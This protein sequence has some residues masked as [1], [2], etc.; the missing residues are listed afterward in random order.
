M[1]HIPPKTGPTPDEKMNPKEK[2][3]L[4]D[5]IEGFEGP[6]RRE[7]RGTEVPGN[8]DSGVARS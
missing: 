8:N 4:I 2:E 5:Q 3:A 1:E 6:D 7:Q